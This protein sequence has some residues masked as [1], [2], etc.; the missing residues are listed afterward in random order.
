MVIELLMYYLYDED[1]L[2]KKKLSYQH[3]YEN[4]DDESVKGN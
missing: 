3:F 4:V 1:K 2:F